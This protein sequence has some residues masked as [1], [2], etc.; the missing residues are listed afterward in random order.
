MAEPTLKA[1]RRQVVHTRKDRKGYVRA[2]RETIAPARFLSSFRLPSRFERACAL[3][4]IHAIDKSSRHPGV[5][6]GAAAAH[7]YG[8]ELH[9]HVEQIIV[10]P[11]KGYGDQLTI[12]PDL[13]GSAGTEIPGAVKRVS[14]HIPEGHTSVIDGFFGPSLRL[15]AVSAAFL[16]PAATALAIV[17]QVLRRLADYPLA[18]PEPRHRAEEARLK[19][20]LIDWINATSQ[21]R[22]GRWRAKEIIALADAGNTNIAEFRGH[23][24][25]MALGFPEVVTQPE[26]FLANGRNV[27]DFHLPAFDLFVEIDG[28]G[29]REASLDGLTV[30]DDIRF[31]QAAHLAEE[32]QAVVGWMTEAGERRTARPGDLERIDEQHAFDPE[33]MKIRDIHDSYERERQRDV[34][35]RK[36]EKKIAHIPYGMLDDWPA[37]TMVL[38]AELG[39]ELDLK[40]RAVLLG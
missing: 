3:V 13:P 22:R 9:G 27:P 16:E 4:R 1:V 14:F 17:G 30:P 24:F 40:P 28:R 23:H 2:N 10:R 25:L 26:V 35:F 32:K 5:F 39:Y 37:A 33:W 8:F 6:L 7:L 34:Y 36:A 20:E 15:L 31:L 21:W 38:E 19:Q 11:A 18:S 29:K 12:L